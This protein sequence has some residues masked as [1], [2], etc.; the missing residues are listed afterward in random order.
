M[1]YSFT[2]CLICFFLFVFFYYCVNL[3]CN[4]IHQRMAKITFQTASFTHILKW[5]GSFFKGLHQD[6]NDMLLLDLLL[7]FSQ[8]NC[9]KDT[10][11]TLP[12]RNWHNSLEQRSKETKVK[13]HVSCFLGYV[14]TIRE[15]T[16]TEYLLTYNWSEV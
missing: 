14:D 2:S 9:C 4:L 13:N 10:Q 1:V 7:I 16:N 3:Q 5:W 6:K 11:E 15:K 8:G 12:W